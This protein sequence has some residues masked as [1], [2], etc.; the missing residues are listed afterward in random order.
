LVSAKVGLNIK[1]KKI[2]KYFINLIMN[3]LMEMIC[4]N[5]V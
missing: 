3:L 4:F 2:I 5:Y 1:N